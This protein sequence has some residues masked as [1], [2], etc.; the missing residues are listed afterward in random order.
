MK[1][2][3]YWKTLTNADPAPSCL[4]ASA[5]DCV[6]SLEPVTLVLSSLRVHK[7]QNLSWCSTRASPCF[8]HLSLVHPGVRKKENRNRHFSPSFLS[9]LP[10]SSHAR[11]LAR[12]RRTSKTRPHA[13]GER[14]G[15][16]RKEEKFLRTATWSFMEGRRASAT[17][18]KRASSIDGVRAKRVLPDGT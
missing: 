8:P 15:R 14:R 5:R 18:I 13:R 17:D 3:P 6:A 7:K 16:G 9:F 10:P 1:R 2:T 4:K 11:T 12:I